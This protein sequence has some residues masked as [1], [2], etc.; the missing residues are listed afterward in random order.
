MELCCTMPKQ[1]PLARRVD[2]TTAPRRK[3]GEASMTGLVTGAAGIFGS[4]SALM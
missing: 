1:L 4:P 2:H 3:K